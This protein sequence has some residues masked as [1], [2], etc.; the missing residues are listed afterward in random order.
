MKFTLKPSKP[1]HRIA[2]AVVVLVTV[3]AL[4]IVQP[5]K[6]RYKVLKLSD[7]WVAEKHKST[8][9]PTIHAPPATTAPPPPLHAPPPPPPPIHVP[10]E[11]PPPPPSA[12]PIHV[13]PKTTA[14]PPPSTPHATTQIPTKI[15]STHPPQIDTPKP[16]VERKP[17]S[18]SK[19]NAV[20]ESWLNTERLFNAADITRKEEGSTSPGLKNSKTCK[21]Y[22]HPQERPPPPNLAGKNGWDTNTHITMEQIA[23]L[24][25][26]GVFERS[27]INY[28]KNL[29]LCGVPK[30]G[31]TTLKAWLLKGTGVTAIK[32]TVHNASRYEGP[33]LWS[34]DHMDNQHIIDIVKSGEFFKSV[35]VRNPYSRSLATF[36]ERFEACEEKGTRRV[37]ECLMWKTGLK[38]RAKNPTFS[39]YLEAIQNTQDTPPNWLNAHW[40]PASLLCG[41]DILVYDFIGRM[42]VATDW[43]T[44]YKVSGV[45]P[46]QSKDTEL[47]HSSG[48]STVLKRYFPPHP[49]K[50][51]EVIY[52]SDLNDLGYSDVSKGGP[53]RGGSSL[54]GGLVKP[55]PPAKELK[56]PWRVIPG[57]AIHLAPGAHRDPEA[58]KTPSLRDCQWWCES[59]A[60]CRGVAWRKSGETHKHYLGCFLVVGDIHESTAPSNDD[61]ESA[62]VDRDLV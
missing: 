35:F 13:P 16:I 33:V 2:V 14:P 38:M 9:L 53:Q 18:P 26:R 43:E 7:S 51:V 32:G 37:N 48:T 30:A 4:G 41:L 54:F 40:K 28:E 22:K 49:S 44:L 8:P 17:P 21:G 42:E 50:L 56:H 60:K 24:R 12:P 31:S 39:Q 58:M 1:H 36:L 15:P 27:Y 6:K 29:W 45:E 62:V 55:P 5:W 46:F 57:V 59:K 10:P 19:W 20:C 52:S 23:A 61:I 3:G 11:T 47:R 34:L 25:K